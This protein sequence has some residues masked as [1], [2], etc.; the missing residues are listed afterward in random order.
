VSAQGKNGQIK[1]DENLM[2]ASKILDR[3]S[4]TPNLISL[5]LKDNNKISSSHLEHKDHIFNPTSNITPYILL[6]AL[7]IHGSIEGIALGVMN[8]LKDCS[9]LF[10]AILLHKWA[11]SFALGI[12][13]YKA[14]IEVKI[15]LKMLTIFTFFTPIGILIGMYFSKSGFLIEGIMLSISSGTFLYVSTSEVIVEEFSSKGSKHIKFWCYLIGGFLPVVL[16]ILEPSQI[17]LTK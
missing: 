1:R 17:N 3:N 15:F 2:I 8:S 12:S 4:S 5:E 11:E 13:F 7:S 9:I 16:Y 10:T 14:K 6:I